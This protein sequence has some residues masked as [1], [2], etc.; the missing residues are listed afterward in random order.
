M[1]SIT[2]PL[3]SETRILTGLPTYRLTRRRKRLPRVL[4]F[5]KKET[6]TGIEYVDFH[7]HRADNHDKKKKR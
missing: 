5:T 4:R 2:D 3:W 6:S 7:F 1:G